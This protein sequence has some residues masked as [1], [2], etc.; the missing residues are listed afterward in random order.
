MNALAAES[1]AEVSRVLR[2]YRN[3][4]RVF[5]HSPDRKPIP[6]IRGSWWY[7]LWGCGGGGVRGVL[8]AIT[9]RNRN[10]TESWRWVYCASLT[11]LATYLIILIKLISG[12]A[13]RAR[14]LRRTITKPLHSFPAN[15]RSLASITASSPSTRGSCKFASWEV[16]VGGSWGGCRE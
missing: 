9:Q 15:F 1:D 3:F 6:S 14:A 13:G 4:S 5:T 2:A 12:A 16:W 11:Q 7:A 8:G 10:P